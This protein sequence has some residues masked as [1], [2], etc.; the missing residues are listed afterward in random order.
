MGSGTSAPHKRFV[1]RVTHYYFLNGTSSSCLLRFV[2]QYANSLIELGQDF[3]KTGI[4][5]NQ[6]INR[7]LLKDCRPSPVSQ[8][9]SRMSGFAVKK[10]RLQSIPY[11][12]QGG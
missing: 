4:I 2:G 10:A 5:L 1:L 8:M 11:R 3:V 6:R 12:A 7:R 9:Y